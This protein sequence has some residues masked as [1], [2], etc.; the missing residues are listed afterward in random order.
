MVRS[1]RTPISVEVRQSVNSLA[2]T[3][4]LIEHFKKNSTLN[5][6]HSRFN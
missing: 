6:K 2:E 4:Y 5:T 1:E 3:N